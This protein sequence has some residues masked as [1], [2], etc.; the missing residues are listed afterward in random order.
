MDEHLQGPE[1]PA[2]G[3]QTRNTEEALVVKVMERHSCTC[4]WLRS[5]QKQN[6]LKQSMILYFKRCA[7]IMSL[8]ANQETTCGKFADAKL[9]FSHAKYALNLDMDT[10]DLDQI[11]TL[12]DYDRL[13]TL[14]QGWLKQEVEYNAQERVII[15]KLEEITALE[16]E[17]KAY[18]ISLME[19]DIHCAILRYKFERTSLELVAYHLN[20]LKRHR[21]KLSRRS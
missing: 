1:V 16:I 3:I 18:D 13:L 21:E 7:E 19:E 14:S 20:C 17:I 6:T 5:H 2:A 11:S 10:I 15:T 12:D 8:A 4:L 9:M